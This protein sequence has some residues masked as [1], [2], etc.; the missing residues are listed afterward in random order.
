MRVLFFIFPIL[1][2][3]FSP[4]SLAQ[5]IARLESNRFV[6]GM[7]KEAILDTQSAALAPHL[8]YDIA[9]FSGYALRP[10]SVS[11]GAALV[12]DQAIASLS[13][14]LSLYNW[15]ALGI[16]LPMTLYQSGDSPIPGIGQNN[17]TSFGLRD[18]RFLAKIRLLQ[19]A[20]KGLD[21]AFIPQI[22][23]P[24]SDAQYL[25]E[26][27]VT[28][29][30]ALALSKRFDQITLASNIGFLY[31]PEK[32][33]LG[34]SI[35]SEA[36]LKIAGRYGLEKHGVPFGV[37]LSLRGG[38]QVIPEVFE[39][40][41]TGLEA[42]FGFDFTLYDR[43]QVLLGGGS[44]I[45]SAQ[46]IPDFRA[47]GALRY[48][49]RNPDLDGDG[50]LNE[51]D[52]C[53]RLAEDRDAFED[54]D[55]CPDADNDGDGLLD[56]ADQCKN[57]AEDIDGDQ[58]ED[59][60]PDIDADGDSLLD[61]KDQCPNE[62]EDVDGFEDEDGCPDADNDGDGLLEAEDKCPNEAEDV[63]GFED[64]DGCPD[65]DND[66]DGL[67]DAQDKCPNEA[68]DLD[69]EEDGDGCPEQ[70]ADQDGVLDAVDQCG[71]EKETINGIDDEDGCPDEGDEHVEVSEKAF[72]LKT[73]FKFAPNAPEL[74]NEALAR[75][76]AMHMRARPKL[77][78]K[79]SVHTGGSGDAAR[80]L[81]LSKERAQSVV[82]AIINA[83]VIAGRLQAE[84][85]GDTKPIAGVNSASDRA[86]N[87]RVELTIISAPQ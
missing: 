36:T 23:L 41:T 48:A 74:L 6:L 79:V 1:F 20:G 75:E 39:T 44:G 86:K 35:G 60:C 9:I 66:G 81:K 46:G 29:H 68:E 28:F 2:T 8:S 58:D 3:L 69:G 21:I 77:R 65:A 7:D 5:E 4:D 50:L 16:Q 55:G 30:P 57:E 14:Q 45:V 10:L 87:R 78:L 83:G 19:D 34:Q 54:E 12:K 63:D 42:L 85:L 24:L 51:N 84:G 52:Q 67:L 13:A 80:H 43:L 33:V 27:D 40:N 31:R 72:I 76:V 38:A 18:P 56:E 25:G 32:S 59:G 61:D 53:P 73:P 26:S 82:S 17:P 64:E 15:V 70:D 62:A 11:N 47:Y 22:T 71:S 49:P 37:N